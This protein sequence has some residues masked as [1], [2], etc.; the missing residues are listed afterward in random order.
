MHDVQIGQEAKGCMTQQ[1][2]IR[3][4]REDEL[5]LVLDWARREGW[6]PGLY[7]QHAFYAADPHGF[8]LALKDGEAAG[9]V[10]AVRYGSSYGFLGL[11]LVK[12]E[13]RGAGIGTALA[14]HAARHLAGRATGLDGVVAMQPTYRRYGFA[15]AHRNLRFEGRAPEASAGAGE[16]LPLERIPFSALLEYD[17]RCFG[18]PRREFLAAWTSQPEAVVRCTAEGARVTGY[19]L[20]RRCHAGRKIGP[21]FADSP[22][23]AR[24]IFLSLTAQISELEP[25]FL[26]V[27]EA[28]QAALD[29][30]REFGM[31]KQF[32]TARM[33]TGEP[34]VLPLQQIFGITT[35][36]LG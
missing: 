31:C 27:P 23:L 17:S 29:L 35:F 34:P 24:S 11:F 8:F 32:E 9:A 16:T 7:D 14:Q 28:N 26:D 20:L 33:Y 6:N 12:P 30:A 19:G 10:S 1:V 25:I 22:H 2:S 15:F 5:A 3:E 13:L 36:E 21:L 18:A 4:M